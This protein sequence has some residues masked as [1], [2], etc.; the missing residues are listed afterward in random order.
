MLAEGPVWNHFREPH[1]ESVEWHSKAFTVHE[2]DETAKTPLCSHCGRVI[3]IVGITPSGTVSNAIQGFYTEYR[4][5]M[6]FSCYDEL[7]CEL[8][9]RLIDKEDGIVDDMKRTIR[10][11]G[12]TPYLHYNPSNGHFK[13]CSYCDGQ[14]DTAYQQGVGYQSSSET[15]RDF[16][17][18]QY[19]HTQCYNYIRSKPRHGVV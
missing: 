6:H 10:D 5:H 13:Y 1:F 11:G 2:R 8:A 14:L 7:Q 15:K 4:S 18:M 16:W 3:E 17:G 19:I 9:Q 12:V